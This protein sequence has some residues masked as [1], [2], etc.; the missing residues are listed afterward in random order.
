MSPTKPITLAVTWFHTPDFTFVQGK[1]VQSLHYV[2]MF[3]CMHQAHKPFPGSLSKHN[4][5]YSKGNGNLLMQCGISFKQLHKR[6]KKK[7]NFTTTELTGVDSQSSSKKR[8]CLK[9]EWKWRNQ[10][11]RRL[12]LQHQVPQRKLDSLF[13]FSHF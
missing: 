13:F 10:R 2:F 6:E 12:L 7:R 3:E 8:K 4:L 1:F 11:W 5:F 9:K